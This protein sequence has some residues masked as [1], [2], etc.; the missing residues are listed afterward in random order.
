MV[1]LKGEY[2]KF[3]GVSGGINTNWAGIEEVGINSLLFV[4]DEFF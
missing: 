3:P 2:D 4:K 1:I